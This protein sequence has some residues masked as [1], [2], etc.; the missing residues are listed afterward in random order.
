M[1]N[2]N[3]SLSQWIVFLL[4]PF[5]LSWPTWFN[6]QPFFFPDTTAYIK[7]AASALDYFVKTDLASQWLRPKQ[8]GASSTRNASETPVNSDEEHASSPEKSGVISGRSIYYGAFVFVVASLFGLKFVSF[9]Q[10]LFAVTMIST[11]LRGYFIITYGAIA[12]VLLCLAI[13]SPLPF[14]ASMLMP[15]IFAGLG[16]AAMAGFLLQPQAPVSSRIF[17]AV[18]IA[19]AALFHSGNILIFSITL[20]AFFVLCASLRQLRLI[21]K[22]DL[23][24]IGGFIAVGVLGEALFGYAIERITHTPPIR[25]PFL[26]A[27]L[28]ADGPG[29]AFI[30]EHCANKQLQVCNYPNDFHKHTSDEF[31][32]SKVPGV[33]VF[34]LANKEA[35]LKLGQQDFAFAKAVFASYPL[36]VLFNSLKNA[37]H[38]FGAIGL[39]EFAYSQSEME[40][41]ARKIPGEEAELMRRTKAGL[42]EFDMSYSELA[43]KIATLV[44]VPVCL[45]GAL[46]C[47]RRR[48]YRGALIISLS[49][50]SL[51]INAAI[52][53][54]FSTPHD[55]YQARILWIVELLALAILL[56][57][58]G[59]A[60]IKESTATDTPRLP[61]A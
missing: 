47:Y 9:V 34:T 25:P 11:L 36:E 56:N 6:G 16:V 29:E 61:S 59:S 5:V 51:L 28:V 20:V 48:E 33:G 39:S 30:R 3:F 17:W 4:L 21:S 58:T 14:F 43:I 60:K 1:K 45:G 19:L 52:C 54:G 22:S 32:W 24:C 40:N 18:C 10:A 26:T 49:L 53:G 27:R 31:L 12:L 13:A 23:A 15:D 8:G 7:G 2:N 38:Q 35:R 57:G 42:D 37:A 50:L 46:I 55:R 41:F 44:S